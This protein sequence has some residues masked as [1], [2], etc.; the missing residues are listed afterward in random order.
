MNI[1]IKPEIPLYIDEIYQITELAFLKHPFSSHTEQ[2]IIKALRKN[3][4]LSIS[5]V[6]ISNDKVVGHIAFSPIQISD[7]SE[8]WYI[9]GPM[10]VHPEFQGKGIGSSLVKSGIQSLKNLNALGCVLLGES[11]LYSR[12]GFENNSNIILEGVPQEYF[13]SLPFSDSIPNGIV[14]YN[15]AFEASC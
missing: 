10:A 11:K 12:F 5:L 13:L 6:A 7:N 3:K 14:K 4:A 8:N 15:S 2:F 1:Q 9:L